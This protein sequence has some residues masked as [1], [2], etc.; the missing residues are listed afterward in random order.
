[1]IEIEI[2]LKID[3]KELLTRRL[4]DS[5]F[6]FDHK[7]RETDIYFNGND[8]DFRVTDEALRIRR[9]EILGEDSRPLTMLTYKGPKLDK[10]S[11]TRREIEVK[12]DDFEGM[13]DILLELKYRPVMPVIKT[14]EYYKNDRMTALLDDVQGLGCFLELEILRDSEAEREEALKLIEEELNK[15]GYSMADTTTTSYLSILEKK[16]L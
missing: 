1:M 12:I 4:I 5:G 10:V 16:S 14:R 8:H 13:K 6:R 9:T 2:K 3:D 15:L 7:V 11:M